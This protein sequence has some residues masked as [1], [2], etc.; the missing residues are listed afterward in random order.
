MIGEACGQGQGVFAEGA[1]LIEALG[2]VAAHAAT[3]TAGQHH[4]KSHRRFPV[5]AARELLGFVSH[6]ARA[7]STRPTDT[8]R[9]LSNPS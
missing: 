3:R 5:T 8:S 1:G 2:L 6:S 4:T 9:S 7:R